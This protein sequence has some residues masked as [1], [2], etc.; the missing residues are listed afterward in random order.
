MVPVLASFCLM[1]HSSCRGFIVTL[2][3]RSCKLLFNFFLHN[4]VAGSV[5]AMLSEAITEILEVSFAWILRN[6]SA[7]AFNNIIITATTITEIA[8]GR[9][10][11]W[12]CRF[13]YLIRLICIEG[14]TVAARLITSTWLLLWYCTWST[15]LNQA[16]E[17]VDNI[18]ISAT[19]TAKVLGVFW[20]ISSCLKGT[21]HISYESQ[22]FFLLKNLN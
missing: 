8:H 18:G 17:A 19:T 1:K 10:F 14:T 22:L 3:L 13:L 7:K 4:N 12:R 9:C 6:K 5:W 2:I 16:T 20:I 21:S 11:F 15:F